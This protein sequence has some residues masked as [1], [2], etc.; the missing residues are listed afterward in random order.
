MALSLMVIKDKACQELGIKEPRK[1][2]KVFA[3]SISE[4]KY[5][6]DKTSIVDI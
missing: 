3:D 6:T 5:R 2:V 1:I 4:Q